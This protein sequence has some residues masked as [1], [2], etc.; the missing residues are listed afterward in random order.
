MYYLHSNLAYPTALII[1]HTQKIST[2]LTEFISDSNLY[3]YV[4]IY[5]KDADSYVYFNTIK[6]FA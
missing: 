2:F 1:K 6:K 5:K 3:S 4:H